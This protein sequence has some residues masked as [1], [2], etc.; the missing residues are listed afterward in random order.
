MEKKVSIK[1]NSK[2]SISTKNPKYS[3]KE[4]KKWN[5]RDSGYSVENSTETWI[6]PMQLAC[7]RN[8]SPF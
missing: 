5:S 7:I 2:A 8:I 6:I 4:A 1:Q 3:F